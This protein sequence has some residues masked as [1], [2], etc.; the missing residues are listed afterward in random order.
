MSRSRLRSIL[1]VQYSTCVPGDH[2]MVRAA[3]PEAAVDEHRHPA[4]PEHEVSCPA[5][6]GDGT[7]CDAVSEPQRMDG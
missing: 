6:T 4:T 5:D 2:E 7:A 1:A 3:V